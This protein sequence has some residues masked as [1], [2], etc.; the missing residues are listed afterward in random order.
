MWCIRFSICQIELNLL[1]NLLFLENFFILLEYS[2]RDT[3]AVDKLFFEALRIIRL[4]GRNEK[5]KDCHRWRDNHER[6]KERE[7]RRLANFNYP[8]ECWWRTSHHFQNITRVK[9]DRARGK[10]AKGEKG[11]DRCILDSS[12][13]ES[14]TTTTKDA[15]EI[16]REWLSN[17]K[18][19]LPR[20]R[21]EGR[22]W[23]RK[24][25]HARLQRA[26]KWASEHTRTQSTSLE[27]VR[28]ILLIRCSTLM[29]NSNASVDDL[30]SNFVEQGTLTIDNRSMPK[31]PHRWSDASNWHGCWLNWSRRDTDA[32]AEEI[33]TTTILR[34]I[35]FASMKCVQ[36][37]GNI[38]LPPSLSLSLLFTSI[39]SECVLFA[40][41]ASLAKE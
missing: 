37:R 26:S 6:K 4:P 18:T 20:Q 19:K 29:R 15:F 10:N 8:L 2:L 7:R 30:E 33:S 22:I 34:S 31:V 25:R 23:K 12:A 41:V 32:L 13:W 17:R 11:K 14:T 5:P 27:D 40:I 28:K 39:E 21:F 38:P 1:L 35:D 9:W 36:T 3:Y 24:Q 16:V